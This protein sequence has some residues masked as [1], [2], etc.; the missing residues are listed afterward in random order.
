MFLYWLYGLFQMANKETFYLGKS[1]DNRCL[2]EACSSTSQDR[3]AASG[4]KLDNMLSCFYDHLRVNH[5]TDYDVDLTQTP[6]GR[7]PL[8]KDEIDFIN[9]R[10][11]DDPPKVEPRIV[12]P[13]PSSREKPVITPIVKN[14][15]PRPTKKN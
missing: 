6:T 4:L 10:L 12:Y 8:N 15:T 3:S 13:F 9:S 11:R 1:S 2:Y 14:R 5:I 7:E